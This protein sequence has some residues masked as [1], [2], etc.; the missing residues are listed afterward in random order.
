VGF[1]NLTQQQRKSQT[2]IDTTKKELDQLRTDL[3]RA[4][5]LIDSHLIN[6]KT[7]AKTEI[8]KNTAENKR[9]HDVALSTAREENA[10]L[11][12]AL[13][14]SHEEMTGALRHE[15]STLVSELRREAQA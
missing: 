8:E 3:E 12:L 11:R 1:E 14:K 10:E 15:G 4:L 7:E 6:M 5:L 9:A 2:E 13:K